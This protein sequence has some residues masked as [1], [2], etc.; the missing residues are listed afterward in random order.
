MLHP[1]G[2]FRSFT[3]TKLAST[4]LEYA[5]VLPH[6]KRLLFDETR[7]KDAAGEAQGVLTTSAAH[8]PAPVVTGKPTAPIGGLSFA[9][10]TVPLP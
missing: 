2:R 9:D 3:E 8:R 10:V 4:G 7:Y 5:E 6:T 1:A